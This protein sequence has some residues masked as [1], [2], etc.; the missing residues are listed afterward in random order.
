MKKRE[1]HYQRGA[2]V[3]YAITKKQLPIYRHKN[4]LHRFTWP[5][6][7]TCVLMTFYLGYSYRDME[8]W[9]LV[10]DKICQTIGLQEIFNFVSCFSS[11]WSWLFTSHAEVIAPTGQS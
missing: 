6:L 5:Q 2:E 7:A 8:D 1:S 11:P 9:L 4:S 10:S 3:A